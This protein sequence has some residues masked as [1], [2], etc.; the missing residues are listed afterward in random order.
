MLVRF[1]SVES[2]ARFLGAVGLGRSRSGSGLGGRRVGGGRLYYVGGQ[3]RQFGDDQVRE[4][5]GPEE[6]EEQ[7]Q[8]KACGEHDA[9]LSQDIFDAVRHG[10]GCAVST[11]RVR[12]PG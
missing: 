8:D 1:T 6:H 7:T 9:D 2:P 5:I 11:A 12:N 10:V 4:R 3:L